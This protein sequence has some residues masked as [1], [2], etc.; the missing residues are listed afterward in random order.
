[1]DAFI[2]SEQPD[3]VPDADPF[4]KAN[5]GKKR[6]REEIVQELK[7]QRTGAAPSEVPVQETLGSK[8]SLGNWSATQADGAAVQIDSAKET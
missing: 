7:R 2:E 4:S 8:V 5:S 3:R 6:T 1:M